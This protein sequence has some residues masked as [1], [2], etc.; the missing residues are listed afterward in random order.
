[1]TRRERSLI[2][3]LSMLVIVGG[4]LMLSWSIVRV[5]NG[6][7][8]RQWLSAVGWVVVLYFNVDRAWRMRSLS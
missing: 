5:A 3:W 4:L 2:F 7:G 1:M 8:W 6:D